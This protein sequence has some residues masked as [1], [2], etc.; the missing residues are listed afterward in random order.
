VT[1]GCSFEL[2]EWTHT[3]PNNISRE[4]HAKWTTAV[5]MLSLILSSDRVHGRGNRQRKSYTERFSFVNW[6]VNGYR[7]AVQATSSFSEM[8]ITRSGNGAGG[9]NGRL[10]AIRWLG[11]GAPGSGCSEFLGI[12]RRFSGFRQALDKSATPSRKVLSRG[13]GVRGGSLD[14]EAV[15]AGWC[16]ASLDMGL[17]VIS[18]QH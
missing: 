14:Y 6:K 17:A 16:P 12:K 7:K 11:K 13:H 15:L 5:R 10:P 1:G 8:S 9:H 18:W 2:L 3:K 4:L